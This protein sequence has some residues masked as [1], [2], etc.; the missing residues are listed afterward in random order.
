MVSIAFMKAQKVVK[1]DAKKSYF[2]LLFVLRFHCSRHQE[3]CNVVICTMV[4]KTEM[5]S[6][7]K[8]MM[9]RIS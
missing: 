2:L 9:V 3:Y 1:T 7:A 8:V 6:T 4:S 5:N